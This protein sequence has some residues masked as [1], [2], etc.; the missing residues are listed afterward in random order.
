GTHIRCR[1]PAPSW[2]V[3]TARRRPRL[4]TGARFVVPRPLHLVFGPDEPFPGEF[5]T[6][7]R[8]F[9]D[10]TRDY[11]MTWVRGLSISYDWQQAVIRAAITLKLSTFDETGGIVAALTTSIP[12][13]PGSGRTWDYRYCWLRDAYFVVKAL[14]RISATQTMEEFISFTLSIA[15]K[16]DNLRPVYSVVPT[17]PLDEWTADE[18]EGYRS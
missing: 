10:R 17:D 2:R 14:N 7:A 8:E 16:P 11:W 15:S 5:A 3:P 1:G 13:A 12:E 18:L 6:V 9:A 4:E